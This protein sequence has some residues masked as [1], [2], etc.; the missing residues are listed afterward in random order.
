MFRA[1]ANTRWETN[2]AEPG[3]G[4]TAIRRAADPALR[5]SAVFAR[6][7]RDGACGPFGYWL[8][9]PSDRPGPRRSAHRRVRR[10]ESQH[11]NADA[12]G[13]RLRAVGAERD[14]VLSRHAKAGQRDV[15]D[16]DAAAGGR[17]ALARLAGRA[18]G[19]RIG[20]H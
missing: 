7:W 4:Y 20:G 16:G 11:E 12:R 10:E 18:L 2:D 3:D 8:R 15:A 17:A 19:C 9:H 5:V 13:Q 14:S 1:T 6:A